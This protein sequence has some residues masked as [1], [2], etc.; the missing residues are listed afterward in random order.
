MGRIKKSICQAC[1][2]SRV[3]QLQKKLSLLSQEQALVSVYH[4]KFKCLWGEFM[5]YNQMS[6]CK[7]GVYKNCNRGAACL[8]SKYQQC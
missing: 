2:G 1:N 6:S 7:C 5:K 4:H 3:F 8:F